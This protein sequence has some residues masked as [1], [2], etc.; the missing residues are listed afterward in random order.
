MYLYSTRLNFRIFVGEVK[1][2]GGQKNTGEPNEN[3]KFDS[4]EYIVF[5]IRTIQD[6]YKQ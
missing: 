6:C 5:I 2:L 1:T 4:S 3:R